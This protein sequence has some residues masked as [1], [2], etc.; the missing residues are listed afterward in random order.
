MQNA[1]Q[2][3]FSPI[4]RIFVGMDVQGARLARWLD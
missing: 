2:A 4:H 3:N 1:S